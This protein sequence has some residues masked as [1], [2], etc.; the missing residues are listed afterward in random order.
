MLPKDGMMAEALAHLIEVGSAAAKSIKGILSLE[1]FETSATEMVAVSRWEGKAAMMSA[2]PTVA[3]VMSGLRPFLAGKPEA[4]VGKV[5]WAFKGAGSDNAKGALRIMHVPL[6]WSANEE[7][8]L[9]VAEGPAVKRGMKSLVGLVSVE[10]L[11]LGEKM[12]TISK[13]SDTAKLTAGK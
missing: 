8:I 6:I 11:L 1:F 12:V 3:K 9:A 4:D 2:A 7:D 5:A 10:V 13:Y